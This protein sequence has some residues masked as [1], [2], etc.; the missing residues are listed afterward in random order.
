[1]GGKKPLWISPCHSGGLSASTHWGFYPWFGP[2]CL[3]CKE[4]RSP[5]S[6]SSIGRSSHFPQRY[7][8]T[9]R[10]V[11]RFRVLS[12]RAGEKHWICFM[13]GLL[14]HPNKCWVILDRSW[15]TFDFRMLN[16]DVF[17]W[18]VLRKLGGS[19]QHERM[20]LDFAS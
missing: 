17:G 2:R 18:W 1:M 15:L 5:G 12:E 8:K 14:R 7:T 19:V 13:D 4:M 20:N 10:N 6:N 3:V 11:S 9:S 16:L